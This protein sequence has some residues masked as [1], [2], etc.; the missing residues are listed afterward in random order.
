LGLTCSRVNAAAWLRS[1]VGKFTRRVGCCT[2]RTLPTFTVRR[3]PHETQESSSN[4]FR[5]RG[6]T[7]IEEDRPALDTNRRVWMLR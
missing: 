2:L 5:S 4:S 7:A 6:D 1:S 3:D